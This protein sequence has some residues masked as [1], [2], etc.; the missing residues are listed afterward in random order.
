MIKTADLGPVHI[1]SGFAGLAFCIFLG[2][3]KKSAPRP[4]NVTMVFLGTILLWFGWFAFNGGS[5][6]AST[7]RAAMAA[8]V[9]MVRSL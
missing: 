4:H 5:A 7:P 1:A 9:S 3:P 2:K 8:L 6:L